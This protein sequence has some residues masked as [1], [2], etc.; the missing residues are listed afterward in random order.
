[1]K[2]NGKWWA[3]PRGLGSADSFFGKFDPMQSRQSKCQ[4][5]FFVLYKERK[6]STLKKRHFLKQRKVELISTYI[7]ASKAMTIMIILTTGPTCGP[8]KY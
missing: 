5:H 3:I 7:K 2:C 8:F 4:M 6:E 1:M